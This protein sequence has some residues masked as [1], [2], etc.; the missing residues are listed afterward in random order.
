MEE[1]KEFSIEEAFKR[2]DEINRMLESP[3]IGLKES[4]ALY[5]EGVAL[6]KQCKDSLDT[7]EK[8][9]IVLRGDQL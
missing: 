4:M 6:A 8:E 2:M 7:V 5:A 3:D 1:K 9:L